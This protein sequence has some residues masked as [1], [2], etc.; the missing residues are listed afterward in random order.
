MTSLAIVSPDLL[1]SAPA[2]P[3]AAELAKRGQ[4][5]ETARKFE[6]SFL[7]VMLQSMFKEVKISEPFGGGE[8]EEM[9]KSFFTEAMAKSM[10][11][12]GGI[13]LAAPVAR[14]MLKLQGLSE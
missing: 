1:Q 2:A 12:S 6:A 8:G 3:S 13:G 7:G 11:R 5:E 4:I 14:E 9:W 10:T